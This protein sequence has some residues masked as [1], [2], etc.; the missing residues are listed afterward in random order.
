MEISRSELSKLYEVSTIRIG[1]RSGNTK[2]YEYLI[3]KNFQIQHIKK[4]DKSNAAKKYFNFFWP[5]FLES[6]F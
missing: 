4:K 3:S 6:F 2:I 1:K 5:F